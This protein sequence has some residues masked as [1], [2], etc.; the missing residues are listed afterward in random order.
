[1]S[2]KANVKISREADGVF[3][4]MPTQD[5]ESFSLFRISGENENSKRDAE[6]LPPQEVANAALHILDQNVSLPVVDL[7]RET[8]R[9]LGYQRTGPMVDKAMRAGI[10]LL[11]RKGRAKEEN[12]VVVHL[13]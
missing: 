4:W 9:L 2:G 8:A 13:W 11:V 3:L 12:D 1:L 5:P 6:D 10:Q 7:V